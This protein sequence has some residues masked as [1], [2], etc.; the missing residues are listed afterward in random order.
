[1]SSDSPTPKQRLR[2]LLNR[3]P[4]LI[5][6]SEVTCHL[7]QHRTAR[8]AHPLGLLDRV[9]EL[10]GEHSRDPSAWLQRR[11]Q[12]A[13]PNPDLAKLSREIC[14]A[15]PTLADLPRLFQTIQGEIAALRVRDS[16]ATTYWGWQ[17]ARILDTSYVN[18]YSESDRR[19]FHIGYSPPEA[20]PPQIEAWL[21]WLKKVTG[22]VSLD[23]ETWHL[24]LPAWNPNSEVILVGFGEPIDPILEGLI[25]Y[26]KGVVGVGN[27]YVSCTETSR[28]VLENNLTMRGSVSSAKLLSY[29]PCAYNAISFS[30][31]GD[32]ELISHTEVRRMIYD[33]FPNP[34]DF[35][36]FIIDK[37]PNVCDKLEMNK[38]REVQIS[39]LFRNVEPNLV[40]KKLMSYRNDAEDN[41][42]GNCRIE[43]Y[44]QLICETVRLPAGLAIY[45]KAKELLLNRY[46]LVLA[47][48]QGPG[49]Q[50]L[51]SPAE[52]SAFIANK[53]YHLHWEGNQFKTN[54]SKRDLELLRNSDREEYAK[55]LL[56]NAEPNSAFVANIAKATNDQLLYL[57]IRLL[58]PGVHV[59]LSI[60]AYTGKYD[61][62]RTTEFDCSFCAAKNREW[63]ATPET[64]GNYPDLLSSSA[65]SRSV[66]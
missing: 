54:R 63:Q 60:N 15:L 41:P 49:E 62:K 18:I 12:L 5:L 31:Y 53:S 6:G 22:V 8:I 29:K 36:K 10:A 42:D 28:I 16:Q 44:R 38:E 2:A 45:E 21:E 1:M 61:N 27:V 33:A 23:T 32:S 17:P 37:F 66:H 59:W 13:E 47:D 55:S 30:A 34:P 50:L 3:R 56:P 48:G 4:I 11:D 43:S 35:E 9:C 7:I 19:V 39:A 51:R 20:L 14:E 65:N 57:L 46:S 24:R 26:L 64:W 25:V 40:A 52:P 58:A